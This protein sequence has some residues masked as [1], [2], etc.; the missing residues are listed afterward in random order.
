MRSKIPLI[1][2]EQLILQHEE[3]KGAWTYHI[4]IPGTARIKG[5]WGSLKVSGSIDDYELPLMNLA[6]RGDQDKIISVN[7]EN[8]DYIGKSGGDPVTVSLYL[9]KNRSE[10][11]EAAEIIKSFEATG[12]IEVFDLLDE[13]SKREIIESIQFLKSEEKQLEKINDYINSLGR[14]KIRNGFS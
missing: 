3:G 1:E 9:H 11:I 2:K 10:K 14:K 6:P 8:R 5:K 13:L 7:Q 4:I 12:V